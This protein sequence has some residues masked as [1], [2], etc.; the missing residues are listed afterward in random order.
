V[1]WLSGGREETPASQT[2]DAERG[3]LRIAVRMRLLDL[4]VGWQTALPTQGRPGDWKLCL[5]AAALGMPLNEDAL[6]AAAM[7]TWHVETGMALLKHLKWRAFGRRAEL[8]DARLLADGEM[9]A[10]LRLANALDLRESAPGR[11]GPVR[12]RDGAEIDSVLKDGRLIEL[13]NPTRSLLVIMRLIAT[14]L[15]GDEFRG[16][17]DVLSKRVGPRRAAAL[18]LEEGSLLAPRQP[19]FARTLLRWSQEWSRKASDPL[20]AFLASVAMGLLPPSKVPSG[21]TSPA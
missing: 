15:Y 21:E 4:R 11:T 14:G 16:R 5:T 18:A 20:G 3:L 10:Y 6:T 12:H 2:L 8:L 13:L 7:A 19:E 17:V 1:G 9:S